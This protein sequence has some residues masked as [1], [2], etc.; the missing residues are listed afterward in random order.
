MKY[1]IENHKKK[2][3]FITKSILRKYNLII[4]QLNSINYAQIFK[5]S[6]RIDDR[7]NTIIINS[8]VFENFI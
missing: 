2:H 8:S 5:T 6:I 3:K 1:V 7:K 4:Q